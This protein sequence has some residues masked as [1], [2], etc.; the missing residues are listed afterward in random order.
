MKTKRTQEIVNSFTAFTKD[1]YRKDEV[2]PELLALQ[3]EFV[4]LTFQN[5]DETPSSRKIWDVEKKL[6]ELNDEANGAA[7]LE[8][9]R[10]EKGCKDFCNM[11]R[12]LI[13]GSRG[14]ARAFRSLE[15]IRCSNHILKNVE[16]TTGKVRTE[17]DAVVLTKGGVFIVEVKNTARNIFIDEKGGFYRTGTYLSYDSN[18]K[19]K[20][21]TREAL[22][23]NILEKTG[24]GETRIQSIL[25]F[26]DT[27]I[28]IKN[29]CDGLRVCFPSQLPHLIDSNQKGACLTEDDLEIIRNQIEAERSTE[30]YLIDFDAT[31]L[32]QDFAEVMTVLEHAASKEETLLGA[33]KEP[34]IRPVLNTQPRLW[35]R[36]YSTLSSPYAR[37]AGTAAILALSILST[38]ATIDKPY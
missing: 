31:Q 17:L 30:S 26:T 22:I 1:T 14:E 20:M 3:E 6:E 11:V 38:A 13:S 33:A 28:E 4:N 37:A 29:C 5:S 35:S 18:I 34:A 24:H 27:R 2:L 7:T 32:K 23:Q 36:L 19:A 12:A 25:V 16:L 21:T 15:Q 9:Q 8:L 10:F